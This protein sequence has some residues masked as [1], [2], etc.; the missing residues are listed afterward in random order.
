MDILIRTFC[1][2]GPTLCGFKGWEKQT[3]KNCHPE[4]RWAI[5]LRIVHR[6]RMDL[7]CARIISTANKAFQPEGLCKERIPS[8]L[9]GRAGKKQILRLPPARVDLI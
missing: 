2:A 4:R 3:S 1:A 9:D 6:S 7:L 8:I 5:R